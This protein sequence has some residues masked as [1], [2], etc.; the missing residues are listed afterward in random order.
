MNCQFSLF[1]LFVKRKWEEGFLS[2]P[3][4]VWNL[5]WF[6]TEKVHKSCGVGI[7]HGTTRPPTVGRFFGCHLHVY[8]LP[9]KRWWADHTVAICA[10]VIW[11]HLTLGCQSFLCIFVKLRQSVA[12][13]VVC[14]LCQQRPWFASFIRDAFAR[15]VIRWEESIV[16]PQQ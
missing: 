8:L 5:C 15:V 16:D 3:R 10:M 2:W 14:F 7:C 12:S 4:D 11:D 13:Q 1:C 9:V 6:D